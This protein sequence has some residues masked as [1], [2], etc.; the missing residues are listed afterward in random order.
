MVITQYIYLQ[1]TYKWQVDDETFRLFWA[2]N[3]CWYVYKPK[4]ETVIMATTFLDSEMIAIDI[5]MTEIKKI[6][7]NIGLLLNS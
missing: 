1:W 7:C 2:T 5:Y 4:D 3:P 6:Y